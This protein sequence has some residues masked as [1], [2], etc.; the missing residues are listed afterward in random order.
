MFSREGITRGTTTE[1]HVRESFCVLLKIT[2]CNRE[3]G[4]HSVSARKREDL[5]AQTMFGGRR[6]SEAVGCCMRT[7]SSAT[8][9]R[10]QLHGFFQQSNKHVLYTRS[11][12]EIYCLRAAVE[13]RSL[14]RDCNPSARLRTP[15]SKP[16][17]KVSNMFL[18]RQ[19]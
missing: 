15:D 8:R 18:V 12:S 14:Y 4:V 9:R 11:V 1:M 10:L 6:K 2:A 16:A 17:Y 3:V 19:G 7:P 13:L 5:T